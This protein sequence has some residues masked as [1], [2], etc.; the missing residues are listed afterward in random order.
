MI[1]APPLPS[2]RS[3]L[4]PAR[5]QLP[6]QLVLAVWLF[7]G[8]LLAPSAFGQEKPKLTIPPKETLPLATK[9]GVVIV[10]DYYPGGFQKIG[11]QI[12]QI[13]GKIVPPII[14]VHGYKGRGSDFDGYASA[15]QQLGYAVAVPDLR[16]HGRS[17]MIRTPGGDVTIDLERMRPDDFK[18][19][20]AD[21]EAVKKMLLERNNAGELNI[22]LLGIVGADLGALVAMHWAVHDWSWPQLPAFKQGRD[23]KAMILLSPPASFR[24][25]NSRTPLQHPVIRSQLPVMIAFGSRDANYAKEADRLFKLFE[26]GHVKP[27]ETLKLLPADASLQGAALLYARGLPVAYESG[28]FLQKH[29]MARGAEFAWTMRQNPLSQ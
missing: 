12:T 6:A 13:D 27:E 17:T 2:R 8:G 21:I 9:D 28:V 15:L 18:A 26:R 20:V 5:G 3:C 7:V 14:L 10:C 24:G 19:M 25:M 1:V 16:G 11:D 29:L 22:E 23:V 4:L